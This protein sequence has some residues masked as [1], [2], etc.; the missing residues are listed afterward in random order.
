M[1]AIVSSGMDEDLSKICSENEIWAKKGT[2]FLYELVRFLQENDGSG[3][4]TK[5]KGTFQ[6]SVPWSYQM[7]LLNYL[8]RPLSRMVLFVRDYKNY[9]VK[10][11]EDKHESCTYI[12]NAFKSRPVLNG[13]QFKTAR[14]KEILSLM[15]YSL[16]YFYEF[17]FL[18][19]K[20]S[21]CRLRTILKSFDTEAKS[22][23]NA[24]LLESVFSILKKDDNLYL[25]FGDETISEISSSD[26]RGRLNLTIR[27]GVRQEHAGISITSYYHI[28]E[29]Y[30][31]TNSYSDNLTQNVLKEV[32]CHFSNLFGK[33]FEK[34]DVNVKGI[35]TADEFT[36]KIQPLLSK[37]QSFIDV[38]AIRFGVCVDLTYRNGSDIKTDT[39]YL[40]VVGITGRYELK[41]GKYIFI[42]C[43]SPQ[44]TLNSI[45]MR[46]LTEL[47]SFVTREDKTWTICLYYVKCKLALIRL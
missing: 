16:P 8:F 25:N 44:A 37:D 10:Q 7:E 29:P 4:V 1:H 38:R 46:S 22:L 43:Y 6:L 47:L 34:V 19:L 21:I 42:D 11:S 23:T 14:L 35:L 45:Y 27:S 15:C 28:N 32:N 5:T 17:V 26:D 33:I 24:G 13:S 40:A 39:M 41:K 30:E 36:K 2:L 12:I 20:L 18:S 9:R 3:A 31:T